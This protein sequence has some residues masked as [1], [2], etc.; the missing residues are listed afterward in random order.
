[1]R[2]KSKRNIVLADCKADEVTTFV[3]ALKYNGRPFCVKSHISNF[4]RTGKFSELRRYMIYFFVALKYFLCR[5]KYNVIVGWQQFYV[6]IISFYCSLFK[7]KKSNILVAANYTYK[8]KKGKAHKIYKWFMSKCLCKDYLDYIHVPSNEYADIISKEF[9]FPRERIIVTT[10][11]VND[12]YKKLS[13]LSPPSDFDKESYALAIG[14]SNR[15]Y[16][17]LIK[18]WEGIDYPL[19]IVCDTFK[20][21]I[22]NPNITLLTDV[23]GEDSYPYISNCAV[24]IVPIDDGSICSGDTVLL[25]AMALKRKIIVTKPSTL[26]EMY[27]KD[28]ENALLTPKEE[29]TFIRTVKQVLYSSEF[30]DLGDKARESFL[31]NFS[32]HSMGVKVSEFINKK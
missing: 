28:K 10:F 4:M 19:V 7:V 5:K 24:M 1:M 32:R 13:I 15:D 12:R 16:D 22:D 11:G 29:E 18:A 9:N 17:F 26:A 14:R 25:N 31:E 8:D 6:L 3:K 2:E 27:V 30:D 23:T 20:G 21:E